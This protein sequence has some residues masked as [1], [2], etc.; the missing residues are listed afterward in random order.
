MKKHVKASL[1]TAEGLIDRYR[2]SRTE[3]NLDAAWEALNAI[4]LQE[5]EIPV[6]IDEEGYLFRLC[7]RFAYALDPVGFDPDAEESYDL[8]EAAATD[9]YQFLPSD[10]GLIDKGYGCKLSDGNYLCVDLVQGRLI[11]SG[12]PITPEWAAPIRRVVPKVGRNDPCPCGSGKKLKKCQ[13]REL[14]EL[15]PSA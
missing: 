2:K 1:K 7:C 15:E 4:F 5:K 9:I 12:E 13:L 3:L 8:L 11:Y 14:C 6:E 10:R